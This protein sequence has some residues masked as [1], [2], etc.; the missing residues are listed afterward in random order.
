MAKRGAIISS[1]KSIP[2]AARPTPAPQ[3]LAPTYGRIS[4]LA[5]ELDTGGANWGAAYQTALP[6]PPQ[7]FTNGAFGPFSPILPVPVDAPE[8]DTGLPEPRLF[9]YEV[10]WNLPVGTPGSEGIKLASFDTLR[11]LADLYSVARAAIQLR[12][13]EVRGIEWEI[14]PTKDASKAMR[15]DRTAMRDFGERR[16]EA[17]KFFKRPDPDYFSWS[18]WLDALLEEVFVFD[19]LSI[20]FRMKWAKGQRKGLLGSDLDSLSLLNGPT[21]RPLLGM[22]GEKPR[23]P[24]PAYQQY[25]YGVP[26][27]DLMTLVTDRD[28]E[29]GALAGAAMNRF[30]AD[31]LLYLP[32]APRRWTPY[33]FPPIERALVPV[34]A[35]LQKQGFQLDYYREGT[36]PAVYVSPGGVNSNMTPNQLRELQDALN[37]I[38]GDPA[39]KHKII[40]LPADSKVLPQRHQQLAD[41]FDEIVMN[42]VCMAFDVQPMELG[43]S[44]K[45]ST[46]QSPGAANQMAK[47][48]QGTHERKATKPTL[49]FLADIMNTVLQDICGQDDM[50]FTF[51]GLEED[52]DEQTQTTLIVQQVGSGLRSIDEG[53]E[54][55]GLQPW[56]LPETSD[57]GWATATGFVPLGQITPSGE[58]ATGPQPTAA[59]PAG[60]TPAG[61]QQSPGHEASE[62]ATSGAKP[63]PSPG[64]PGGQSE[65]GSP[66]HSAAQAAAT[67]SKKTAQTVLAKSGVAAHQ[68]RRTDRV[69]AAQE[70]VVARLKEVTDAYQRGDLNLLHALDTGVTA[71]GA[72]YRQVMA[73]AS[74]DA[75]ADHGLTRSKVTKADNADDDLDEAE[76]GDSTYDDAAIASDAASRAET[77]RSFLVGLLKSLAAGI[78]TAALAAR[79][80]LYSR[81]LNGAYNAAYGTTL[82]QAPGDYEITWHLGAAEHCKLCVARD[83]KTYTFHS[84]PGWPG[85]GG[86]G[87]A[88]AVCLGGPNCHCSLEYRQLGVPVTIGGNVQRDEAVGYYQQQLA[89]ITARR[90]AAEQAREDFLAS[91]PEAPAARAYTRDSI[92]QQLADLANERIRAAGGYPGVSVEPA[93]IPASEVAARTP[94]HMKARAVDAELEA[95]ARHVR[96]GRLISTWAPRHITHQFLARVAEHMARG[97]M[98]DDAIEVAKAIRRVDLNGQEHWEEE[99]AVHDVGA[100]G[101]GGPIQLPHDA[102]GLQHLQVKGAADLADPNPVEA[103]HVMNQLRANYPEEALGWMRDA[104][105][106][107][108]VLVPLDRIDMDDADSWAASHEKDR[109]KHFVK[110]IK[111]GEAH[112]HPIVAVQE[113]GDDKIKV[114]DGHHRTLAY[115]KLGQPVRAY[116]GFVDHDG[117]PWDETHAYQHHQ[118]GD[119][120]NKAAE[121]HK[122]GNPAALIRWYEAGADGAIQW[123]TPGDFE[124]CVRIAGRHLSDPEGFCQL[125]H[126]AATGM[127][128]S[129]HAHH[130]KSST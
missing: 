88:G 107:G 115:K 23:P 4:P 57:P 125:R 64:K 14:L 67:A 65:A 91:I 79:L 84:L 31:Q 35:G 119:P 83:G 92:R 117:G 69:T 10:G 103:E 50:R 27:T 49:T 89:D 39:W 68:Q 45:V 36:V 120:A 113:P 100:A 86:F 46:T 9:Q 58:V 37:A 16:A 21:I 60:A 82:Q 73:A 93:D 116:V 71:L 38:A 124:Q 54:E 26:R 29:D 118:G 99:P 122:A 43:I 62:G 15:G 105:W 130:G 5:A 51:E 20:L 56:G 112:L 76:D 72:G 111:R 114:I 34:M 25:L 96:K 8:P 85:D 81:T 28:L 55:L 18:S 106:I 11:T 101:G 90:D 80:D 41:Q 102:A 22:H 33:G 12:K 74:A 24:A 44:P 1:A 6:R 52:E 95:L 70:R 63:K 97:L 108:P 32:M 87:G 30:R 104:R 123:G 48:S 59:N 128:T 121:L 17:V 109:V 129:Q 75:R 110:E 53:R 77:Q 61:Q 2:G 40:V 126:M 19:A 78:T 3:G 98:V 42:Q 7:D 13:A 94:A 47:A 66:G 127:T